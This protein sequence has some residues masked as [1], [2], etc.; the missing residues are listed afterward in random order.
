MASSLRWIENPVFWLDTQEGKK[1]VFCQPGIRAR[2][3][4]RYTKINSKHDSEPL[5]SKMQIVQ[6][7]IISQFPVEKWAQRKTKFRK[8][9]RKPQS[10]VKILI[11]RRN[12]GYCSLKNN[13]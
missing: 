3:I 9:T 4:V 2:L 5:G 12:L 8:M 1:G 6:D 10:F 13:L 7:S 11:Y